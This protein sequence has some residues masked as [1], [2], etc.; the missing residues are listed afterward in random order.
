MGSSKESLQDRRV[1][2]TRDAILSSARALFARQGYAAT[3]VRPIAEE[4]GVAVAT[5]YS[6]FG[7]KQGVLIALVDRIRVETGAPALWDELEAGSDAEEIVLRGAH[8][9]RVILERCG[10][11]VATMRE[12]AA[13]DPGVAAA[14]AEGQRRNREGI[15][16]MCVRLEQLGALR[17]GLSR[18]RA[19]DGVAALFAEE[20]Y[21]ELTGQRSG[22]TPDEYEQWLAERLGQYLL[23]A[24]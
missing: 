18:K 1:Q 16:R 24:G 5:L 21:E 12:G 23:A 8:L 11:I 4:A 15:T 9:R 7:S 22:W 14:Y 10:D 19:V 2:L 6:T 3:A 20:T 17:E 13:G